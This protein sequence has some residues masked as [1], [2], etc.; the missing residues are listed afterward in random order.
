MGA[1]KEKENVIA[2]K[3]IG[4]LKQKTKNKNKGKTK[5]IKKERVNPTRV[6]KHANKGRNH[7]AFKQTREHA[8]IGQPVGYSSQHTRAAASK[9]GN[10]CYK[11]CTS[12]RQTRGIP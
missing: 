11:P 1:V 2:I 4:G 5:L 10:K 6:C 7:C 8:G 3:G 9:K 12:G